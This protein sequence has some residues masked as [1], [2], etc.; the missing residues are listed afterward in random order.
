[1]ECVKRVAAK[2]RKRIVGPL[3]AKEGGNES[4]TPGFI[5]F[6]TFFNICHT[7]IRPVQYWL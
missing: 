2:A 6:S 3:W 7:V 1:M 5:F 4:F